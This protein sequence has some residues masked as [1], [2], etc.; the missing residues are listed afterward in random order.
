MQNECGTVE[1]NVN[2]GGTTKRT[3]ER[4]LMSHDGLVFETL[5]INATKQ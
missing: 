1:H 2:G 4:R 3:P 5:I